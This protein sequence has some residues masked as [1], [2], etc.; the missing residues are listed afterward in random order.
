MPEKLTIAEIEELEALEEMIRTRG[1]KFFKNILQHHRLFCLDEAHKHLR[2]H[3]DRNAG[4]WLA[5]SKEPHKI[6]TLL[7][8]RKKELS[9]KREK[10][11]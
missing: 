11:Y 3:A 7:N 10:E 2:N 6:M 8:N 5:R 9:D 4:E 1:W